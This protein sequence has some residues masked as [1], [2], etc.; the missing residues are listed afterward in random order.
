MRS[1]NIT[2]AEK[3]DAIVGLEARV[4]ASQ[5]RYVC[6]NGRSAQPVRFIKN[7]QHNSFRN[8]LKQTD[9]DPEKVSQLLIDG[10]PE[11]DFSAVGK[12]VSGAKKIYL[13]PEGEIAYNVQW[14][15]VI[16]DPDGV[17]KSRKEHVTT[18][19]N[20]SE[21][22]P[23]VWTGRFIPRTQAVRMFVCAHI[24]QLR[25][26]N[27]LTYDFLYK[28]AKTLEAKDSFLLLGA[29][30]GGKEPIVLSRGGLSYR[31]FLSGRTQDERYCLTLHLSNLE[32]KET[33]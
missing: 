21:R 1:I 24:Y 32:L 25:H 27:G 29:G 17:E 16:H 28:M 3:R 22:F 18:R 14:V 6:S 5:L 10:D 33:P 20:I 26:I 30:A 13:T 23:L 31:G 15:D 11:I 7:N 4:P 2:D 8:L 12:M 19:A 9:G